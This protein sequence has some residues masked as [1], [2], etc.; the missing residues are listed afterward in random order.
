MR[1]T[2]VKMMEYCRSL[3]I[4]SQIGQL[5]FKGFEKLNTIQ[6]IVFEQAYRTRENLLICAP[7]GAGE[8]QLLLNHF[9]GEKGIRP[10]MRLLCDNIYR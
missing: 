1:Y 10:N 8:E 3:S 2:V 5:G 4:T 7:T 9:N 6:S